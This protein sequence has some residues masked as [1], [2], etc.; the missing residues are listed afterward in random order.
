MKFSEMPYQRP[1]AES[2][3]QQLAALTEELAAAKSFEEADAVFLREQEFYAHVLTLGTLVHIRHDI[4][5]RDEFYDAEQ[6]FFNRTGPELEEYVQKWALTLLQS[7]FRAD[8]AKKYDEVFLMNAEIGLK[9]FSPEI[10]PELQKENALCTEYSKLL[11]SAQIPFEGRTYTIAQLGVFKQDADDARRLAAWKAEGQW[12]KDNQERLDAIY[13]ELVHLRDGMGRKLG[14]EDYT[15]LGYRRMTRNCYT[16]RD[17]EKFRAAVCSYVVPVAERIYRA[18]AERLGREY[19]LSFAD[20][21]LTF[22]SGNA[23]PVGTPDEILAEGRAFYHALSPETAEFIDT[24]LDN[25]LMD[26]LSRDGKAGG[27][28]CTSLSDYKVPF[29]FANFNGTSADVETVTHEAGHAFAGWMSREVLPMES[30]WPSLEACEVHSMSM[31]FFAWMW[32]DRFY[33]ADARKFRYSHLADAITFI[34]YGTMVD[35]FQ[36]E[37]YD[38]PNMTPAERHAVWKRL[39]GVYMPWLR[40]D[41]EIPFYSDGEGWQRQHHI[42]ET[43]YYYIDY[44][45]AQTMALQFWALIQSDRETAWQTYMA[46]TKLGG[47]K[48]FTG[49]IEAA[50]LRSPFGD[51]CL[52]FVCETAKQWLDNYD[53]TGIE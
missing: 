51:D 38:H 35:H 3:K 26:V 40:L 7:P 4:D 6:K 8:F 33:G 47:T 32:A 20:A 18:Q 37:V 14:G 36:H 30:C 48:T 41:G 44:C 27:G 10:I 53:L 21:A 12:Y 43:P 24:M 45:L 13:D 9:T 16:R 2:V 31:E 5:T 25:E 1:D 39:L 28:Y 52:R 46:Y 34:P 49:L 17:V 22:R 50:G 15:L 29:I 23:K 11:A 19:P 42:Y